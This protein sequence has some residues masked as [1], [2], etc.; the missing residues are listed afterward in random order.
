MARIALLVCTVGNTDQQKASQC[1]YIRHDAD[2]SRQATVNGSHP[3][4]MNY[5]TSGLLSVIASL[6]LSDNIAANSAQ[7]RPTRSWSQA[8]DE[9]AWLSA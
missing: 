4:G 8:M 1:G 5:G 9:L 2:R 7:R 3:Q 6:F